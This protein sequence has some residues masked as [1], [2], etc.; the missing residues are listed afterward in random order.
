[1]ILYELVRINQ[2]S[3]QM[4]IPFEF[5]WNLCLLFSMQVLCTICVNEMVIKGNGARYIHGDKSEKQTRRLPVVYRAFHC[6]LHNFLPFETCRKVSQF[7]SL[8]SCTMF[9]GSLIA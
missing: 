1:M 7:T 3:R 9:P 4:R 2:N 8:D 5:F 6:Y